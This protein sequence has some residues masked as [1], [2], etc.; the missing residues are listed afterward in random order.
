MPTGQLPVNTVAK[1][2]Q[3]SA[4][5]RKFHLLPCARMMNFKT[6]WQIRCWQ[7]SLHCVH[8]NTEESD[9][10]RSSLV[11]EH[12]AN[13]LERKRPTHYVVTMSYWRG[14]MGLSQ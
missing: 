4:A 8:D 5:R 1:A 2:S 14:A 10:L 7:G 12:M 6:R 13:V 9:C 3:P 11:I